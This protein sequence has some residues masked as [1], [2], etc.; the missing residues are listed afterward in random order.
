MNA[1][2]AAQG[3]TGFDYRQ[4][5][6]GERSFEVLAPKAGVVTLINN[7]QLAHIAGHAGAPKVKS[8]GVDLLCKLGQT[9]VKGDVLYRV[10]ANYPSD[11]EFARRTAESAS[12]Y[13]IGAAHDVPQV[14]VEF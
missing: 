7:L 14:S 10:H 11:L 12:G 13:T 8:A 9:V 6:L 5:Q 1:I 2:I 4:P 3:A